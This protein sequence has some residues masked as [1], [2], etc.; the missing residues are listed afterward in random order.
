MLKKLGDD[1]TNGYASKIIDAWCFSKDVTFRY[2]DSISCAERIRDNAADKPDIKKF[3][4][5][6]SAGWKNCISPLFDSCI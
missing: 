5:D 4:Q 3:G 2:G 1:R 6:G